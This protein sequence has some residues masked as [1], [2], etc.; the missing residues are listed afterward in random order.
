VAKINKIRLIKAIVFSLFLGITVF[1]LQDKIK[2]SEIKSKAPL[3]VNGIL[4]T[5]AWDFSKKGFLKL[6][7]TW[8]FYWKNFYSQK[9][10][11]M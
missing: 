7:G 4:D 3:A 6:D 11:L 5:T 1:Y 8:E 2:T 9:I 10:F